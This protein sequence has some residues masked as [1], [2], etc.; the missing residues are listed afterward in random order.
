[1]PDTEDF[2]AVGE[3]EA[4][5]ALG[6]P[7]LGSVQRGIVK[8]GIVRA[9]GFDLVLVYC[10]F[11]HIAHLIERAHLERLVVDT[12]EVLRDFGGIV[13]GF[14]Q[15]GFVEEN[16]GHNETVSF[17]DIALAVA[18]CIPHIIDKRVFGGVRRFDIENEKIFFIHIVTPFLITYILYHFIYELSRL[19][20]KIFTRILDVIHLKPHRCP[21]KCSGTLKVVIL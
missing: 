6:Q 13:G 17:A 20:A 19:F 3:E 15:L 4:V 18:N 11:Q 2:C 8:V 5:L 16:V 7:T 21:N 1:M 14:H 10:L 9:D 12:F